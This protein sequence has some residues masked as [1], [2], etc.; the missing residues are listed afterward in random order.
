MSKQ[1]PTVLEFIQ[2]GKTTGTATSVEFEGFA[3]RGDE[4]NGLRFFKTSVQDTASQTPIQRGGNSFTDVNGYVYKLN[5]GSVIYYNGS[6]N[7]FP[8]LGSSG[9]GTYTSTPTSWNIASVSQVNTDVDWDFEYVAN[10]S[11]RL[12]S[13][14]GNASNELDFSRASE[15]SN[16]N[17]SGFIET[18]LVDNPQ[19]T[20]DGIGSYSSLISSLLN[21]E[22]A[23]STGWEPLD[24]SG[25]RAVLI[26]SNNPSPSRNNNY[27][28]II[29][30]SD[31]SIARYARQVVT[32][33]SSKA[34]SCS[35]FVKRDTSD[36]CGLRMTWYS[37]EVVFLAAD[38]SFITKSFQ[39]TPT[40]G[41]KLHSKELSN[42]WF[43]LS[44]ILNSTID[45]AEVDYRVFPASSLDASK[46]GRTLFWGFNVVG[47][48]RGEV[49]YIKT[50]S[51]ALTRSSDVISTKIENNIPP[52]NSSFT[53]EIGASMSESNGEYQ[54]LFRASVSS[55]YLWMRR[56]D[57]ADDI[58]LY[59]PPGTLNFGPVDDE[60]HR[61]TITFDGSAIKAFVDGTLVNTIQSSISPLATLDYDGN[62][63]IGG[64]PFGGQ[65][66]NSEVKYFRIK[67]SALTDEQVA[68]RGG[69]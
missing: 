49:P 36:T 59:S 40:S 17:K 39:Y 63:H 66:L 55:N 7:W 41:V 20:K 46:T 51:T 61:F 30:D 34:V 47:G 11:L 38:F 9:V 21:S 32:V 26:S 23:G 54:N 53:F 60:K 3:V 48:I 6:N 69:Y 62:I 4:G 68:A 5:N 58:N 1:S 8:N 18:A 27:A 33:N 50:D 29:E 64:S 2:N 65:N 56:E 22:S 57:I 10:D 42:G 43:K 24:G 31:N 16:D 14:Y 37:S 45:N 13:G 25:N 28:Q 12:R 44:M 15:S 19:I 52:N 35:V 67:H